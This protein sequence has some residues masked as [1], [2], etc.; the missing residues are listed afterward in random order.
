MLR[1]Y[2]ADPHTIERAVQFLNTTPVRGMT[3]IRTPLIGAMEH[4]NRFNEGNVP[5]CVLMTDGAVEDEKQIVSAVAEMDNNKTRVL[6][7]GIGS[8]CNEYFLKMLSAKTRGWQSGCIYPHDL[9]PKISIMMERA[10]TPVLTDVVLEI[11]QNVGAQV[12]PETIPDLFVNGP[13]VISGKYSGQMP[14]QL[15]LTGKMGNGQMLNMP[16]RVD[17]SEVVPIQ[18]VMIKQRMDDLVA[19]YWMTGDEGIKKEAVELSVEET[20]PSPVC[21]M[22]RSLVV[23]RLVT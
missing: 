1:L 10:K 6:T 11:P 12:F 13:I 22:F 19:R 15:M 3:D 23:V 17:T 20:F 21:Y 5:F 4:L 16:V 2:Q 18:K 8:F 9:F 7:F 14:P